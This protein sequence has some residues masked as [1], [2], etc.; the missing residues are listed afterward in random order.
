MGDEGEVFGVVGPIWGQARVCGARVAGDEGAGYAP[1]R[2]LTRL[3][4]TGIDVFSAGAL[5]AVEEAD[6]EI[7]L[8]DAQR[9]VY[10][11]IVLRD[12]KVV[13]TVLY[14]NVADGPW[15]VQLM[16]DKV[17]V[18]PFRDL[19]VFGRAF[20]EQA[21]AALPQVDIAAMPDS[22]Q[23]CGCNGVSKGT[24]CHA[25]A[26]KELQTLDA[27]RAHTKASGSCGSGNGL[28]RATPAHVSGGP[29]GA[30]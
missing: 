25:I 28:V 20:A 2:V 19:L 12:D 23:I 29:R 21:G 9:G 22:E 8:H 3:K 30:R 6:D 13:G 7:T 27:V 14:G 26:N 16:R 10:K 4:I 1:P 11:K 15:Y 5:A 18:A 17:D 24:I